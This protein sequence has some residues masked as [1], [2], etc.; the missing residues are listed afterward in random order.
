VDNSDFAPTLLSLAGAKVP[1]SMQGRDASALLKGEKVDGWRQSVYYRYWMHMAHHWVPAHFGLRTERY[2][3]IF[4]YGMKLDATG[5]DHPDCFED[6]PAGFELYDLLHDPE[7]TT[8]L[9]HQP[10]HAHILDPLKMEMMNLKYELGDGDESYPELMAL[11]GS[12]GLFS[13]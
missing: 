3:L 11:E 9:A 8:N 12:F 1:E 7:E 2:K 10:E 13:P 5:C 4:F 6:T